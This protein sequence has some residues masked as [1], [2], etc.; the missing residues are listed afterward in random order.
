MLLRV[1]LIQVEQ[2]S[3]FAQVQLYVS[4]ALND[5][6]TKFVRGCKGSQIMV[7]SNSN[8]QGI[9]QTSKLSNADVKGATILT[10]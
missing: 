9:G 5:V 2:L 6:K 3:R 7:S 1:G 8:L 4:W 10:L